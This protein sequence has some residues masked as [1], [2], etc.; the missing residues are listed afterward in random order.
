[1]DEYHSQ[2][3]VKHICIRSVCCVNEEVV[4]PSEEASLGVELPVASVEGQDRV[5]LDRSEVDG[6]LTG[7]LEV[8]RDNI[9]GGPGG[10]IM[11]TCDGV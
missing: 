5:T 3:H 1:M 4:S 11:A 9:C 10:K 6:I 8:G 2:K 7:E